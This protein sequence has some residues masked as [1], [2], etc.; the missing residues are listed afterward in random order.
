MHVL[1]LLIVTGLV[2]TSPALI[3]TNPLV[4]MYL[5]LACNHMYCRATRLNGN[6]FPCQLQLH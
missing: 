2:L 6:L 3:I 5:L 4:A 1:K